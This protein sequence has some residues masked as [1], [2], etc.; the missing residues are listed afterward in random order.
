MPHEALLNEVRRV[1]SGELKLLLIARV[2]LPNSFV[3]C[4]ARRSDT[5][6]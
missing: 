4:A 6:I 2:R 5:R 1:A 3:V